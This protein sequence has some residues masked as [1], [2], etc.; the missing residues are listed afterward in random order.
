MKTRMAQ[1]VENL[2]ADVSTLSRFQQAAF[3]AVCGD[4]LMPMY[5]DF[6]RKSGWGDHAYLLHVIDEVWRHLRNGESMD[7]STLK[8][9]EEITPH[10]DDFDAPESTFA[11]DA[12]ICIDAAVRAATPSERVD[13]A[14]VEFALEPAKIAACIEQTGNID[15]G[16][17]PD[18]MAWENKV[19]DHPYVRTEA[20]FMTKTIEFLRDRNS[21]SSIEILSLREAARKQA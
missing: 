6:S 21:L 4:R 13:P 15:A 5:T 2:E 12:A 9:I 14:W 17:D 10:G 18:G 7:T 3:F 8:R 1:L 16:S 20:E 19:V 11:Q